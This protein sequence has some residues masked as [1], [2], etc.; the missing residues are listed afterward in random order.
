MES[1]ASGSTEETSGWE[2]KLLQGV[3]SFYFI[4]R[5]RTS[6]FWSSISAYP[7][8]ACLVVPQVSQP[9]NR[10]RSTVHRLFSSCIWVN[11]CF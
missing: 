9:C 4:L 7:G 1:P 3:G 5:W 2:D 8:P 11:F 6:A 10:E